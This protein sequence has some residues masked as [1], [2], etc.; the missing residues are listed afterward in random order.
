MPETSEPEM[1]NGG[2]LPKF[3]K[4]VETLSVMSRNG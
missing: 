1:F 4:M 2:F 3:K